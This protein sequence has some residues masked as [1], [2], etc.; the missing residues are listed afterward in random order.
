LPWRSGRWCSRSPAGL[1]AGKLLLLQLLLQLLLSNSN[2]LLLLM[3][4]STPL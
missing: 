4:L 3:V 2:V 1:A